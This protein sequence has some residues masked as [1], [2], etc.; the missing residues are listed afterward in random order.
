[1]VA[2]VASAANAVLLATSFGFAEEATPPGRLV[3]VADAMLHVYC[4]GHGTPAVVFEAGLG[5]NYLDWTFVQAQVGTR[6]LACSYDRAGAGWS[7]RTSRPRTAEMLAEELH[8]SMRA[9]GVPA[10]FV[11]VGHSFGGLLSQN[12][13]ARYPDD[14]AGLVLVDAMHPREF[15]RFAAAGVD[16]PRDPQTVLGRTPAFAATHGLPESL[17]PL[18]TRLAGA[19]KARVFVVREMKAMFGIADEVDPQARPARP[20]RVLTH[21]NREWD[22]PYPDGRMEA[23]WLAMQNDLATRFGAPPVIVV[24]ASGH[25]IAL[26]APASVE[27]AIDAVVEEVVSAAAH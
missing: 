4:V 6:R 26:D 18:A 17:W 24:P 11:L 9:A 23:A 15:T 7:G 22:V 5:G 13:L 10:P 3:T 20:V 1:M 25:Q 2:V 8:L 12:Y 21:G 27:S 14:V 16:V 19:D